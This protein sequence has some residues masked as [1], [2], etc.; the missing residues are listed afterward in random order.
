M[1]A[2]AWSKAK[3]KIITFVQSARTERL[4]KE[5]S[6]PYQAVIRAFT[7]QLDEY[8]LTRPL[9][10]VHPS[11]FEVCM[12]SQIRPLIDDFVNA[13]PSATPD[14]ARFA[15]LIPEVCSEWENTT[16]ARIA[17]LLPPWL[18]AEDGPGLQSALVW[19]ACHHK[20]DY[21]TSCRD[22]SIAY[23]RI[24]GHSHTRKYHS[25]R[26]VPET[27]ED[28][29]INAAHETWPLVLGGF[30][31]EVMEKNIKF[32]LH[33]SVAACEI[34]TL[35]G[36]DPTTATYS[37]MDALDR[38]IACVPC[39]Q[40]MTWRKAVRTLLSL[41]RSGSLTDIKRRFRTYINRNTRD[42]GHGSS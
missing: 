40:V 21:G 23:P 10:D 20:S 29:L 16:S 4:R 11:T 9:D 42:R 31:P 8:S 30:S 15:E 5:R 1:P 36:L 6:A 32:D 37:D 26:H 17:E 18:R 19:F 38:R 28:D 3:D 34:V 14:T 24:M 2:T 13:G 22:T 39:K 27:A 12:S 7:V 33:A 41:L 35:C 25:L